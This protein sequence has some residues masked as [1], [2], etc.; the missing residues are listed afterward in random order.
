LQYNYGYAPLAG[1]LLRIWSAYDDFRRQYTKFVQ[2]NNKIL[3][4]REQTQ[5]D[6]KAVYTTVASGNPWS[7]SKVTNAY[8]IKHHVTIKYRYS[9]VGP[10]PPPLPGL[11]LKF[12]GFRGNP[13]VIWDAIPFSFVVD[14]VLKVGDWLSK[15]DE[16]AIPYNISILD[17]CSSSKATVVTEY[18][19]RYTPSGDIYATPS[20]DHFYGSTKTTQYVRGRVLPMDVL[21]SNALPRF[22]NLS[23]RELVLGAALL[24]SN[25]KS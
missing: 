20:S 6:V 7:M 17:C 11:F 4:A 8:T 24:N 15:W 5:T 23:L 1:D 18:Y 9:I 16:G 21:S 19:R 12:L 13:K 25:R 3:Y 2:Q 10:I 14:W 22:D